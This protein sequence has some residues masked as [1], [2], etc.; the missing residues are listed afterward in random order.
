[1]EHF[2]ARPK[3]E[4]LL[5]VLILS[6]LIARLATMAALPL[7]DT[8][9]ARYA[10]SALKMA[11]MG[12]WVTPWADDGVPFWGKPPLSFWLTAASFRLFGVS[13][14]TARLPHFI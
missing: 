11:A 13:E 14:F 6:V 5:I 7:M 2:W 4:R 12:D 1:M 10:L 3:V 9:E 8:T